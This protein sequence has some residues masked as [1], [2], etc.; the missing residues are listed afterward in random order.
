MT[1]K[2]STLRTKTPS[3]TDPFQQALRLLT[4]RD[5]SEAELAA[6][7]RRRG[8]APAEVDEALRRCRE[9]GYVDDRRYA[10]AR[11]RS[12]MAEGRAVGHR[13]AAE[14]QRRGIDGETAAFAT[15]TVTE[16]IP[17]ADLLE[18]VFCHRF[19]GFDFENADSRQLSRIVNYF[20]RRGFPIDAIMQ[21]IREK[22]SQQEV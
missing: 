8:F 17:L 22:G 13:L 5:H 4:G 2:T 20:F 15:E 18:K 10:V 1:R 6:K 12:L 9:Y 21:L 16:E 3:N 19:S 11:A 14:L 7:L